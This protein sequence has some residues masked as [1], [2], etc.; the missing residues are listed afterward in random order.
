MEILELIAE[1]KEHDLGKMYKDDYTF[2]YSLRNPWV[3]A[4]TKN[5]LD[6]INVLIKAK[7]ELNPEMLDPYLTRKWDP[8]IKKNLESYA[9]GCSSPV[10]SKTW[11]GI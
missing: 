2:R 9:S 1:Q 3:L 4:A 11:F 8:Q 10:R 7:I 6:V 5:N